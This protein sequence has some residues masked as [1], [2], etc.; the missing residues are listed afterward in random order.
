MVRRV[1]TGPPPRPNRPRP[2]FGCADI[3]EQYAR[4]AEND[5]DLALADLF[6]RTQQRFR[7]ISDEGKELRQ[8]RLAA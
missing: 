5:G 7:Q 2:S 1:E 3:Y 8:R 6:R 4:D